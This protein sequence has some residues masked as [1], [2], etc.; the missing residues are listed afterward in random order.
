MNEYRATQEDKG[1]WPLHMTCSNPTLSWGT[2]K[3]ILNLYPEAILK[4]TEDEE[5]VNAFDITL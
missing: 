4:T 1:Q 5:K 3:K 2:I